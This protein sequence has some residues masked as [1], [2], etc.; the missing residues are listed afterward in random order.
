M[1]IFGGFGLYDLF[2]E[3]ASIFLFQNPPV[4][5]EG[6]G[7]KVPPST[8]PLETTNEMQWKRLYL[9]D[10]RRNGRPPG[11]DGGSRALVAGDGRRL[12]GSGWRKRLAG[13]RPLGSHR[14]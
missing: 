6:D 8:C 13:R 14:G 7:V 12:V 5:Q 11:G 1:I 9:A 4:K 2:L 10:D 3:D